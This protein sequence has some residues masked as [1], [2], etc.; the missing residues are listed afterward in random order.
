MEEVPH[1]R[2]LDQRQVHLAEQPVRRIGDAAVR[3]VD[4]LDPDVFEHAVA[5]Q[6]RVNNEDHD[7]EDQLEDDVAV[8]DLL[9]LFGVQDL[10]E[11]Q[12]SFVRKHL[13]SLIIL[14]PDYN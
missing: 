4:A 1:Y 12:F 14:T 5:P 11:R 9:F 6:Q 8:P 2:H 13:G 10:L 3:R 7:A